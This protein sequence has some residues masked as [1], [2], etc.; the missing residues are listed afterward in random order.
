MTTRRSSARPPVE[1]RPSS[2][3]GS[4]LRAPVASRHYVSRPR[5]LRLL[6]EATLAP[7][8]LVAAPAGSGKTSLLV[9]WCATSSTTTAW[10]SLDEADRQGGQL[11][12]AIAA[13]VGQLLDGPGAERVSAAVSGPHTSATA[14]LMA[15]LDSEH[16]GS[17]VLVVDNV[18][19]VDDEE[20]AETSLGLFL[21]SLPDWLHVVLLSRRTP[22]LPIDRLRA[23]GQ[24]GEVHFTELRFSDAEAEDML[25]RLAPS[26]PS[27]AVPTAVARAG[28]WAAGLQLIALAVRSEQAQA[29]S[30]AGPGNGDLLF[31]D[32]V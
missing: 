7:I 17:A 2:F 18:D 31:A 24:L 30:L 11:W 8:T 29:G 26:L 5:L 14:A 1:T 27:E 23:R 19:L 22:R 28:G 16:P 9:D 6:D 15:A 3:F 21:R 4:R 13:A 10:V 20:A 32:Y 12:L 25:S